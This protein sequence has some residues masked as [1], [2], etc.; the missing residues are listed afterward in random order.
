MNECN[1]EPPN[2]STT[3]SSMSRCLGFHEIHAAAE[4]VHRSSERASHVL[5]PKVLVRSVEVAVPHILGR[6]CFL[7][8]GAEANLLCACRRG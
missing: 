2:V 3:R 1:K 4:V 7:H 6:L 8:G 5:M